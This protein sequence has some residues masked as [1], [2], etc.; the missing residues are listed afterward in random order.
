MSLADLELYF[1]KVYCCYFDGGNPLE[2]DILYI[3]E[4]RVNKVYF[5]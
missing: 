3:Y 4:S 2:N 1:Y 5:T